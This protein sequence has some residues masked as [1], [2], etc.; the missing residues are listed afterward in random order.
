MAFLSV[1]LASLSSY[2]VT[3]LVLL[4]YPQL[5]HKPKNSRKIK[6]ISHRGGAGEN[7]ENTL[8]VL[9]HAVNLGTDICI[10]KDKQVVVAH[11]PSLLRIS[12]VD[13]LIEDLDYHQLP[14]L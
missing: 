9:S 1:L 11:D 14:L 12:G 7:Y 3:S 4:H 5:L 2:A 8:T 13:A 6:H 10:T